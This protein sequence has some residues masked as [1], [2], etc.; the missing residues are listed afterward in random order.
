MAGPGIRG[1]GKAFDPRDGPP[2]PGSFP[3]LEPTERCRKPG[4]PAGGEWAD[5]RFTDIPIPLGAL[6]E[7]GI[8]ADSVEEVSGFEDASE[9]HVGSLDIM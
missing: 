9:S 4:V 3:Y 5:L 7:G 1:R 8:E 6:D 2:R